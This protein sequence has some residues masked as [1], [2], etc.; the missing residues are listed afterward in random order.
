MQIQ[1]FYLWV[2]RSLP[3][4]WYYLLFWILQEILQ[5]DSAFYYAECPEIKVQN[6][7]HTWDNMTH[8]NFINI[9]QLIIWATSRTE[10]L[11]NISV[12]WV[13][14]AVKK[15]VNYRKG[16]VLYK[17]GCTALAENTTLINEQTMNWCILT[18]FISSVESPRYWWSAVNVTLCNR[19][20]MT[21][22]TLIK[23]SGYSWKTSWNAAIGSRTTVESSTARAHT[24]LY[25]LVCPYNSFT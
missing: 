2:F 7:V 9:T 25:G 3:S 14:T 12:R 4:V 17:E 16:S 15:K 20:I 23:I 5:R 22:T 13:N 18:G 1:C 11:L 6:I 10:P 19:T 24:V 21:W 8:R